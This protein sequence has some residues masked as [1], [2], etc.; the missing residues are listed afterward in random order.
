MRRWLPGIAV[1]LLLVDLGGLLGSRL[2]LR[3]WP[4][5]LG[6]AC[7][8]FLAL[9]YLAYARRRERPAPPR[10]PRAPKR[11]GLDEA[12]DLESDTSTDEQRWLM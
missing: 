3:F 10:R 5:F 11:P 2:G 7:V 1:L 6:L 8:G 4:F 9:A 12:Y